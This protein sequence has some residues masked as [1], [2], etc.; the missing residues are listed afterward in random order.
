MV[1]SFLQ[2]LHIP[3]LETLRPV[4]SVGAGFLRQTLES[5]REVQT[6][7]LPVLRAGFGAEWEPLKQVFFRINYEYSR[8][9]V[10]SNLTPDL[11]EREHAIQTGVEIKF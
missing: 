10:E 2:P 4:V 1:L 11:P 8:I 9:P 6:E 7:M 5:G 3:N